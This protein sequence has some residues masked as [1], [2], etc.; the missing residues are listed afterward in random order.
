MENQFNQPR[1]TAGMI[2]FGVLLA[3][4]VV[5]TSI[6]GTAII[7]PALSA[8]LNTDA[9]TLQ[10][11][12]NAFNLTFACFTLV[13]GSLADIFGCKRSF[14][15]GA[16][17]YLLASLASWAAPNIYI[18]DICRAIAGMGGAAL[19]SC[20]SAVLVKAFTG[21]QRTKAFALFGT[22][23]GLGITFGPTISGW[24]LAMSDWRNI[25]LIHAIAL[26]LVLI[27]SSGLPDDS[28]NN[29]A[30]KLDATGTVLFILLLSCLMLS[31]TYGAHAGWLSTTTVSLLIAG[32]VLMA[33]FCYV[34]RH[35]QN[36]IINM[37][38]IKN[39]RFLGMI[40]I[41]VVASFAFVP[42]L[43]YFPTFLMAVESLSP[44]KAGLVMLALTGPVLL[45]PL[46]AAKWVAKG[47]SADGVLKI[48]LLLLLAG[49]TLLWTFSHHHLGLEAM[50]IS[51]LLVG[52]GMGL[53]AGL[54][55][56]IA[57]SLVDEHQVGQ[58]A[59]ILNT[60]RLGS[61]AIAVAVYGSLLASGIA[62]AVNG[63]PEL[64]FTNQTAER[65]FI[66]DIMSGHADGN[67][68][69]TIPLSVTAIYQHAFEFTLSALLAVSV[70]ISLFIVWLIKQRPFLN[71][72]AV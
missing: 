7:L 68:I 47:R 29:V 20:G 13:W 28:K 5:P 25:F 4:F 19:F 31:I 61:E 10:W 16:A 51:L 38:L 59:G 39:R 63:Y 23:A 37:R 45:F 1:Q 67:A 56:G 24:V 17:L 9:A 21:Q 3:V 60:F 52:A 46:L 55:D 71:A 32:S 54:V 66:A 8:E 12:V 70:I 11:A 33:V 30:R 35:A 41:P 62:K 72:K 69:G 36:P 27:I 58:A 48:S 43:T 65:R 49:L 6:S 42:L 64:H 57:L 50:M 40:L 44:L 22:T 14:L 26:F 18:L 15:T 53:S 34:E 2:L